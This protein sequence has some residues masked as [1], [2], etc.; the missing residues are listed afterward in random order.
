M[1]TERARARALQGKRAGFVSRVIAATVD[2]LIVF[3]LLL[4]A[5]GAYAVVKYLFTSDPL[6]LPDPGAV[7]SGVLFSAIL[8]TVLTLAWSG[9]GRTLG[10]AAIG[11]RV[12][13]ES[14]ARPTWRR[15]L[16]RALIVVYIPAISM[17]WILVS[18]KNAG[19]HDLVCR[20]AVIYD[21]RVGR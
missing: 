20:T 5:L 9:S 17:L 11:L 16:L 19:L 8:V 21:W 13:T 6:E 7:W 3:V 2:V 12:L 14:G 15:A 4:L 18:R 10:N 1:T